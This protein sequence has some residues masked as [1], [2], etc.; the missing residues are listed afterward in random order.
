MNNDR[1]S[2]VVKN[3][4]PKVKN[5]LSIE[6]REKSKSDDGF[7]HSDSDKDS[8]HSSHSNM[9]SSSTTNISSH[10]L[11]RNSSVKSDTVAR[12]R[13]KSSLGMLTEKTKSDSLNLATV[14]ANKQL[15]ADRQAEEARK[16]RKIAD[17]EIS[18]KSL[19]KINSEL[20]ATNKKQA[21][22]IQ[23]LA[24]RLQ[25]KESDIRFRK[26]CLVIDT[27]IRDG[28]NALEYKSKIGGSRVLTNVQLDK[29][30]TQSSEYADGNSSL[31]TNL[32]VCVVDNSNKRRIRIHNDAKI[33]R[34][35][36]SPNFRSS[37]SSSFIIS[38]RM[39]NATNPSISTIT[40]TSDVLKPPSIWSSS[41][42]FL[43]PWKHD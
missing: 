34:R 19:M 42:G 31:I 6:N 25:M 23:D 16:N 39:L 29:Q 27:L 3:R 11:S 18:I 30:L 26:I 24:R 9:S 28:K 32:G 17:L 33:S 35:R 15:K 2:T 21:I 8:N 10:P 43:A 14:A 36:S 37:S 5:G 20:D 1:V 40:T 41:L 13:P 22:E 4:R 7:H 38:D 12:V